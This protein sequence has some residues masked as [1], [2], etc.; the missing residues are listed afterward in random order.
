[1]LY[2]SFSSAETKGFA[3]SIAK[4]I[5]LRGPSKS[6]ATVVALSGELGSGKT[7]FI[8]GFF[9]GLGIRKRQTSPTFIIMRR[10]PFRRRGFKNVYH[11]DAYRLKA[12][13]D[14]VPLGFR[15]IVADRA[16]IL[17]V[18][19]ADKLKSFLPKHAVYIRLHHGARF[20][21]RTIRVV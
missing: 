8:Q 16:Q 4:E 3:G 7:T 1:M 9:R 10:T 14:L 12:F 18:E 17:V 21:E 13:Y 19:W 2:R 15:E 6:G 5:L 11:V 20:T